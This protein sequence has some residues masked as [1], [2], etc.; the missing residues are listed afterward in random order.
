VKIHNTVADPTMV[1]DSKVNSTNEYNLAS[2]RQP[3]KRRQAR[4]GGCTQQ[5]WSCYNEAVQKDLDDINM[6]QNE[7]SICKSQQEGGNKPLNHERDCRSLKI[8][9]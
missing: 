6:I 1:N 5:N 2:M 3:Q 7:S 8:R 9:C 4:D